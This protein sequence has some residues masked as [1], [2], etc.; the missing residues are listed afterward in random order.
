MEILEVKKQNAI[1]AFNKADA[2]G[3]E[4]LTN[5]FPGGVLNQKITDRVQGWDDIIAISGADP[6][7]YELRPD[8]EDDELAQRMAKLISKVYNEG[9]VLDARDTKQR[10]YFPYGRIVEYSSKPSG[11]GL[12]YDDCAGWYSVT[13]VGVRLCFKDPSHAIDAFKKFPTVYE[14][15]LIR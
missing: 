5:L 10:K 7:K 12:S 2:A 14:K 15:L 9:T 13:S 3:K 11:F 4:L 8:E 6:K 1:T